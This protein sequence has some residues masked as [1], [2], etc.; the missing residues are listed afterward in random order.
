[1]AIYKEDIV[2]V[3]L[4]S[5]SI[6]RSFLNHSIG[7][8][9]VKANRFGVQ[10]YR[11][12]EP[13][14][15]GGGTVQGIFMAPNGTNILVSETG[16][17]GS[18]GINGNVAYVQ[19]PA[20]CYAVEG[21][22]SLAIILTSSGVTGTMRIVDGVID[23]TGAQ[24]A[25]VPTSAVPTSAQIIAAYE[26][27]VEAIE[28]IHNYKMLAF[29]FFYE[30][31]EPIIDESERTITFHRNC[32]FIVPGSG[33]VYGASKNEDTVVDIPEY[34][35]VEYKLL[36][37]DLSLSSSTVLSFSWI[38]GF[39]EDLGENRIIVM[40]WNIRYFDFASNFNVILNGYL[41]EA[42]GVDIFTLATK[43]EFHLSYQM[44]DG[45]YVKSYDGGIG[46]NSDTGYT[47]YI[48]IRGLTKV[49]CPVDHIAT[50][51][52]AFYDENKTYISGA[53]VTP[54][55]QIVWEIPIPYNAYYCRLSYYLD[56]QHLFYAKGRVER[57]TYTDKLRGKKLG[58]VGDSISTYSGYIPSGYA[59]FYPANTVQNVNQ[60]WW[61]QLLEQTGMVLCVNASWSG[62]TICG[63]TGD[64]TGYV[65]ASDARVAALTDGNG[66]KPDIIIC[67]IGINDFGKSNGYGCGTYE[68][69]TAIPTATTISNITE[70]YGVLLKKLENS[71]P[72][73]RIFVC[74]IMPEQFASEMAPSYANGF[75]NINPTDSI[76]LPELNERIEKIAGAF[77]AGVI[78]MDKCGI[79]FFNLSTYTGDKLHPNAL[80]MEKM[81][82]V[83]QQA[84]IQLF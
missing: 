18:T 83:A 28:N 61:K 26:E 31:M 47:G 54:E 40:P 41:K 24:T 63:N 52:M 20:D 17:P 67:F 75:P 66:N 6:Y 62:S 45:G 68:G 71:Y 9:D 80:L 57:G 10:L 78:P 19:L 32:P 37:L 79:T 7:L 1:M 38:N 46:E 56:V 64:S 27:A 50:Y 49:I 21:R 14:G 72:N 8:G 2:A 4:E 13:V 33:N 65:G 59:T 70:A 16:Y 22:F 30:G 15:I 12:K 55:S 74:R 29:H 53:Q 25:V 69:K 34:T 39:G 81:A 23:N 5:G 36:V 77:G 58:I 82:Q 42:K 11:N 44:F 35:N 84:L 60:T 51:Q 73:A 3:E 48:Y 43:G 76:S